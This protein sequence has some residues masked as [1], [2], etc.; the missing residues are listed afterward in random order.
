MKIKNY[1]EA[2]ETEIIND[3]SALINIPSVID[4][5]NHE[6]PFGKHIDDAL[7]WTLNKFEAIGMKI[8]YDPKGYYGYAEIG[9]G[10][11]LIGIL[12]HVD[13]VPSGDENNWK[14]S[15]FKGVH[16]DGKLYGRGATDDKGPIIAV[17]HALKALIDNEI[18]FNKR[19]RVIIGTDEENQWRGIYHYMRDEEIPD[20][21]FTPDSDFPVIYA[22]KGLLQIKLKSDLKA[23]I[24][25]KGGNA[26]NSVPESASYHGSH[27]Y[28]LEKHLKKM[29]FDHEIE[30]EELY[31]IGKSAHS[32]KPHMGVN[33]ISR[34]VMA[35]KSLGVE[36]PA[37]D[38]IA[39]KIALTTN[40][41]LIFGNCEDDPSGKLT[42]SVNQ[43]DVSKYGEVI[44]LD[45]RI[46]VTVDKKF[47]EL[48]LRRVAEKFGLQ[49]EELD[50]LE[51]VYVSM[52]HPL[53]K[54]L[55]TVYEEET[56]LDGT[57]I[58][59][60]GATYA[61]AMKNCVAFGP[62]FPGT[63]KI[64]HQTDEYIEIKALIK[65]AQIYAKAIERMIG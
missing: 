41:E 64:A 50:Y 15:P 35:L 45:I 5:V 17:L 44:A 11:E 16:K 3:L 6:K 26:M 52:D 60:G 51:P 59:T 13:V 22:E 1:I 40:G 23:N 8:F 29:G 36:T 48:G 62:I 39:E 65:C 43:I 20:Y 58:S 32:A 2:N 47:I 12:A 63:V 38:F 33:A 56:G 49:Y 21:G 30:N 54:T 18:K 7:K 27:L 25:I 57:P 24:R 4:E 28:K 34:M 31:V 9:E 10:S 46:P 42:I 14:F 19:V 55:K 61:R 53:I 37:I